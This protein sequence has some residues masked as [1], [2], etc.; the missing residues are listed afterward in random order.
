MSALSASSGNAQLKLDG[1]R[2][3]ARTD[4]RANPRPGHWITSAKQTETRAP[5]QKCLLD[6][7]GREAKALLLRSLW[8]LQ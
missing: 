1:N 2:Q 6:V 8:L 7:S 4:Y 3:K 5:D